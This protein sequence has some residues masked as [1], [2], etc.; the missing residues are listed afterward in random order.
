MGHISVQLLRWCS[1]VA[2]LLPCQRIY[3]QLIDSVHDPFI[4]T[5]DSVNLEAVKVLDGFTIHILEPEGKT[6][7][8]YKVRNGF[9]NYYIHVV[10]TEAVFIDSFPLKYNGQPMLLAIASLDK[11]LQ[12]P[13]SADTLTSRA[14]FIKGIVVEED[15]KRKKAREKA[16]ADSLDSLAVVKDTLAPDPDLEMVRQASKE[17]KTPAATEEDDEDKSKK[18]KKG[19]LGLRFKGGKTDEGELENVEE[20]TPDSAATDAKPKDRKGRRHKETSSDSLSITD[21]TRVDSIP[22]DPYPK[23]KGKVKEWLLR[24]DQYAAMADSVQMRIDSTFMPEKSLYDYR[25]L[26]KY[27]A[28][29][30]RYAAFAY[31]DLQKTAS[32]GQKLARFFTTHYFAR[33]ERFHVL[34][35]PFGLPEYTQPPKR[36]TYKPQEEGEPV[37][38]YE[39]KFGVYLPKDTQKT[40]SARERKKQRRERDEKSGK[41]KGG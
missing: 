4:T 37:I 13:D 3:G 19:F 35:H 7:K 33:S 28:I 24:S 26:L 22:P 9:D 29:E 25:D 15:K 16:E 17:E 11:K 27:N 1:I 39:Y 2:L 18:K 31:E 21:T 34:S 5:D 38:E 8:G 14:L 36:K 20:A 41:K 10:Y 23:A 30:A 12:L 32:S 40:K 6:R